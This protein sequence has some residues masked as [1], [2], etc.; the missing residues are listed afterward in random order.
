MTAVVIVTFL[1]LFVPVFS[2]ILLLR[3]I[4]SYV[5]KPGNR[6][7]EGLVSITE[8][9]LAPIRK[10]LPATAGVDFAPLATI[11]LLQALVTMANSLIPG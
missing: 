5:L 7:L 9:I 4:L 1:N 8:P 2:A 10:V 3:I 6:F 11:L